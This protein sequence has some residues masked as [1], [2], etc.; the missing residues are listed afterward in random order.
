MKRRRLVQ[1]ACIAGLAAACNGIHA[2]PIYDDEDL[3]AGADAATDATEASICS[4]TTAP[5]T[6]GHEP[7][8]PVKSEAEAGSD[9]A[10]DADVDATAPAPSP[11]CVVAA[12][13]LSCP[14]SGNATVSCASD[15]GTCPGATGACTDLCCADEYVAACPSGVA[16]PS[17]CR[18][19]P[20]NPGGFNR[21]YCCKCH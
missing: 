18:E 2:A 3:D 16:I 7:S 4:T 14:Y 12:R 10:S 19:L 15:T 9:A 20:P 11:S 21:E 1:F 6:C 5:A 17:D 8:L 13:L